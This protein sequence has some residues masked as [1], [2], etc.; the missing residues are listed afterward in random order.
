MKSKILVEVCIIRFIVIILLIVYHSF[1]PFCYAWEPIGED[2]ENY[3]V[4]YWVA[5]L[6][7][8]FMLETFVFISG[9]IFGYQYKINGGGNFKRL[10][11]NKLKRI[12]LPSFIFSFAYIIYFGDVSISYSIIPSALE[13]VG[14]M[15]FLPMLFWCFIITTII[16]R[17]CKNF[18]IA[19]LI[20]ACLSLFSIFKMPFRL[21][22]SFNYIIFFY[23]GFVIHRNDINIGKS[24]SLRNIIILGALYIAVVIIGIDLKPLIGNGNLLAKFVK[25]S[26]AILGSYFVYLVAYYIVYIKKVKVSDWLIWF[27]NICFGI[28]ILQE[29]IIRTLYYKLS[30]SNNIPIL[31]LPWLSIIITLILSTTLTTVIRKNKIGKFLLG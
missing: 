15:W 14:H 27:S 2:I 26:Y 4:Y 16:D 28:Y 13:G 17:I 31:L 29:F 11:K 9:Y 8:S 6:S 19:L 20:V 7:Y 30:L 5:L 18:Y 21:N 23:M 3:P 1:A 22:Q 10:F 24:C 12:I 25:F